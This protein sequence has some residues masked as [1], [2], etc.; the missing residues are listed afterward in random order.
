MDVAEIVREPEVALY[1]WTADEFMAL[2]KAGLIPEPRRVELLDGIIIRN[3]PP[4]DEHTFIVE[5]LYL[6]FT[7]MG[8]HEHG[9]IPFAAVILK[10]RNAFEPDFV[11]FRD[12]ALGRFGIKREP[13]ILWAVE[14]SVS[15]AAKDLG[16]KKRAYAEAG[17]PYYWVV[18]EGRRGIWAFSD[19]VEGAYASERFFPEGETIPLP[20]LDAALDTSRLFP[21]KAL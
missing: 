7:R 18:D 1:R 15:S 20:G 11:R 8:L 3:M 19:P 14:V 12:G 6:A 21:P 5:T 2:I 9:L 13:D 10:D 17:I 4:G 16:P